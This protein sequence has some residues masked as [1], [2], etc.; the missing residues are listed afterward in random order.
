MT[1]GEYVIC[2]YFLGKP[3]IPSTTSL[4]KGIN[5]NQHSIFGNLKKKISDTEIKDSY[6]KIPKISTA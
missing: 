4:C 3:Y 1:K 2:T 5:I 6:S